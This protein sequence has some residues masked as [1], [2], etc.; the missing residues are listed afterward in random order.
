MVEA[1]YLTEAGHGA[2]SSAKIVDRG[3]YYSG[4]VHDWAFEV[5]R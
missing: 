4:L 3:D 2:A 1:G 5:Q